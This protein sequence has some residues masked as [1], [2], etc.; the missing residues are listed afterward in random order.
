MTICNSARYKIPGL[1]PKLIDVSFSGGDITSDA[2]VLLLQK[3]DQSLR[4]LEQ[5]AEVINDDRRQNSV[6]HSMTNL[7]RQRVYGLALGYEDLNDHDFLKKDLAL[8]TALGT[9]E[10]LGSRATLSRFE[11]RANRQTAVNIHKILLE[12]FI[13]SFK[14]RPSELIFDFDATD[15]LIHGEQEGRFYHGYYGN[16]CFLPLYVTCGKKLLVAYLRQSNQ[17]GAK[18]AWAIL[19]LLV[20][21]IRQVWPEVKI[22]FRGDGGFCRWKML[23]WCDK[24]SV[25]YIVGIAKNRRLLSMAEPATSKAREYYQ[26]TSEKQR[27]FYELS[28]A[29]DSWDK[30]RRIIVKAEHSEKG[31]NPRFVVTNLPVEPQ[32][33]YEKVYCARGEMENRIKEQQMGLFADRTSCHAFWPNQMRLLFSTLAYVLMEHIR[34]TALKGT[35]LSSAQVNT[36][37]LRLFKIGAVILKNTR[38]IRFLLSS[39]FPYQDLFLNALQKLSTA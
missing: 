20:K 4:L 23:R 34:S 26:H 21:R 7:L 16:Y 17:D 38:R 12:Q 37:R 25:F 33:L 10:T 28:Y 39:S 35:A 36:I 32:H 18:H 24:N 27:V 8:Q 29:A 15:D 3:S 31:A 5:V 14:E 30:E 19:A 9:E 6:S 13:G 11:N 1:I 2:G 22:V